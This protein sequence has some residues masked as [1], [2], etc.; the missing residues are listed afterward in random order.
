MAP[1][2]LRPVPTKP[3]PP[4]RIP[5][6][7]PLIWFAG[8]AI[9]LARLAT[10]L[11]GLRLLR[12]ASEPVTDTELPPQSDQGRRIALLRNETI[13]APATWGILRSVILVPA[14]FEQLPG[15]ISVMLRF[16]VTKWR[17]FTRTDF[18]MRVLSEIARALIWF[19]PLMW[20]ARRQLREEQELAC[21][22]RVL[23]AGG[24]PST[25]ARLLLDW[26]L[27]LP[28]TRSCCSQPEWFTGA[29][30][31]RRLYA[32]LDQDLRRENSLSRTA[33]LAIWSIALL[34]AI[35]PLAAFS[36]IQLDAARLRPKVINT[37][38]KPI[39]QPVPVEIAQALPTTPR[40]PATVAPKSP[41]A[42]IVLALDKSVRR[43]KVRRSRALRAAA[44]AS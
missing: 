35:L 7:I 41:A 5:P 17:T 8:T 25:Y 26:D 42:V 10:N 19:Q 11:R 36:L 39:A 6:L 24:K 9:F 2:D 20:I 43:W 18:S 34:T 15:R 21:D 28:A 27:G 33:T 13:A 32:L 3:E 16:S 29:V 4:P 12:N 31:K 1:P 44:T 37:A 38:S 22:N 40:P 23:A 14:G 30:L